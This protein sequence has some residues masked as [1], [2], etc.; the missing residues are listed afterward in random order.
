MKKSNLVCNS[1]GYP[2]NGT[3][4]YCKVCGNNLRENKKVTLEILKPSQIVAIVFL[5]FALVAAIVGLFGSYWSQSLVYSDGTMAYGSYGVSWFFK[6]GW[7]AL[8]N[9]ESIPDFVS[10]GIQFGFE[11]TSYIL[12][13]VGILLL[14]ITYIQ[15]LVRRAK[16]KHTNFCVMKFFKF[17]ALFTLPYIFVVTLFN[18]TTYG[19]GYE[20]AYTYFAG[21]GWGVILEIIALTTAFVATCIAH[22]ACPCKKTEKAPFALKQ[23]AT[24]LVVVFAIVAFGSAC[25]FVYFHE[26]GT[27]TYLFRPIYHFI[28]KFIVDTTVPMELGI[29]FITLFVLCG[30]TLVAAIAFIMTKNRYRKIGYSGAL[31]VLTSANLVL[32][33]FATSG[34]LQ[35]YDETLVE[36]TAICSPVIIFMIVLSVAAL[37]LS[38]VHTVIEHKKEN[39]IVK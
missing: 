20:D 36:H 19:G 9:A 32:N 13:I 3:N 28:S 26:D 16:N 8:K 24:A 33:H 37:T 38:I 12:A 17:F 7:E 2:L 11:F 21:I 14:T 27:C 34:Y 29:S 1:C 31:V 22:I 25:G 6:D 5:G 39:K 18:G 23:V 4:K 35:F 10:K 15:H 30:L